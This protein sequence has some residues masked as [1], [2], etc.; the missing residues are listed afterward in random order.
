[1]SEAMLGL[2][3][4]LLSIGVTYFFCIRPMRKG[5]PVMGQVGCHS[6]SDC[7]DV[8]D[9]GEAA[10]LRAEITVLK[11]QVSNAVSE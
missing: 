6:G 4:L 10:R 5:I 2:L 3:G 1:M 11:R 8:A 7:T 9:L